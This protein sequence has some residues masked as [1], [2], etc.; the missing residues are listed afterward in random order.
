[1]LFLNRSD[2]EQLLDLD[3]LIEGLGAAMIELSAGRVSM[4]AR[5]V[6]HI[7]PERGPRGL[8]AAMPAYLDSAKT[9]AAKLVSVYP[10]NESRGIPSHQAIVLVFDSSTGT[11]AAIMDGTSITATRTACGS[12]LAT[13]VLAQPGARILTILGAGV[14]A[15]AHA[16]AI[17]RVRRIADVRIW[18]RSPQK[19][20]A[21]AKELAAELGIFVRP[22]STLKDS[23]AGAEIVCATTHSA[24]PVVLGDWLEPGAHVNSV[25][26]NSQGRE[27]DE[28]AVLKSTVVVE[29]REAALAPAPSGANDLL[30]SCQKGLLSRESI[31]EV[32]EILSGSRP[33]RTSIQ[34]ITLYKSV[35]VA[36]QDA[37]AAHLVL[38]EARR[39]GIGQEVAL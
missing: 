25:G 4:P 12:A 30:W 11:P 21:L 20:E 36:V 17:P 37:V 2:V 38:T 8:F 19:A 16:R 9:L 31:A 29:S 13:R 18:S 35:G 24:E 1:M 15:R 27:V 33:G 22:V 32:G 10:E 39:R 5:N 23:L 14:Q 3:L 34:Q 28:A 7:A 26:L 6:V